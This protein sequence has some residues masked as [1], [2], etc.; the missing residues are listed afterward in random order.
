M[1]SPARFVIAVAPEERPLPALAVLVCQPSFTRALS[2]FLS[3][4]R[5][6]PALSSRSSSCARAALLPGIRVLFFIVS[7]WKMIHAPSSFAVWS[8]LSRGHQA[9]FVGSEQVGRSVPPPRVPR[10]ASLS[11]LR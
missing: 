3:P 11:S 2:T 6:L 5:S 9:P 1:P 4:A 7:Y 8:S 10:V